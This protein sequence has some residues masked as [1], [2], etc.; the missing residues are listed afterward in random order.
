MDE[1]IFETKFW[2]VFLNKD[3]ATLGRCIIELKRNCPNLSSLNKEE[4]IDFF[5]I[6]ERLE[7]SIKKSF[8]AEMFN[9]TCLM[10][11]FYKSNPPNPQ[12]H[13]H[14]R[15]RYRN[16]VIFEGTKFEDPEFAHHYNNNRQFRI[17]D[18]TLLKK[19]AKKIALNS[20]I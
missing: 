16:P 17:E 1:I 5:N 12:L 15:P 8:G 20:K 4:K 19:I 10:N 6:V 13:W 18:K 3:Q 9:W 7:F 14:C 2:I 11:D